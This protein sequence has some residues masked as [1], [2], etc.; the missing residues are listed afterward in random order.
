MAVALVYA[1]EA[2]HT[3]GAMRHVVGGL[4]MKNELIQKTTTVMDYWVS[5][6][7]NWADAN[8][9]YNHCVDLNVE[10]CLVKMSK[11]LQRTFDAMKRIY[12]VLSRIPNPG[13][14]LSPAKLQ[15]PIQK[16]VDPE[17]ITSEWN[18]NFRGEPDKIPDF[19]KSI[20]PF[21]QS[22]GCNKQAANVAL[23]SDCMKSIERKVMAYNKLLVSA[24]AKSSDA[25]QAIFTLMP[26][27]EQ[28]NKNNVIAIRS[29]LSTV[30]HI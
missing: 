19:A 5:M 7:E 12:K 27:G 28:K 24:T 25:I 23:S 9:E 17:K 11:Y 30:Q 4:Q 13:N 20:K 6:I 3:R 8:K 10:A 15:N 21:L 18:N 14:A 26:N 1:A 22:V 2:Y 29:G 16:K